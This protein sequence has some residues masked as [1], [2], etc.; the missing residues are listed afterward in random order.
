MR[1]IP[2]DETFFDLLTE[3]AT[4]LVIVSRLL[5]ELLAEAGRH[6]A[7]ADAIERE[8][9]EAHEVVHAI[10]VRVDRTFVTPFDREDIHL[11]AT[12]L[13]N[14]IDLVDDTARRVV[15]FGITAGRAEAQSLAAVLVRA[16]ERV[17]AA[18]RALR[19]PKRVPALVRPVKRLEEEG[20]ALYERA[21]SALFDER[22][23]VLEV[24]KWKE[25]FD[26]LEDAIDECQR[27]A[28]VLES[29]AIKHA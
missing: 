24:F 1:L 23:P 11:L 9:H 27:V 22:L 10:N 21:V 29:V 12:R 5:S 20:D 8:E 25:L 17:E 18:V 28:Q 16:S 7:V 13:N 15:V 19:T 2:V 14:A 3:V 4:R 26:L 6:E